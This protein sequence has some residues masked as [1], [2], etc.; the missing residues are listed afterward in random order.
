MGGKEDFHWNF[1]STVHV[2]FWRFSPA[3][4]TESCLF[5]YGL[6]GLF[7]LHKLADKIV[8]DH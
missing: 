7:L 2:F 3:S 4:L 5:W 1:L 6:K 8:L